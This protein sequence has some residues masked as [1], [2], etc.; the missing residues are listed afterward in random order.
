MLL[1]I[2]MIAIQ[3]YLFDMEHN[4]LQKYYDLQCELFI[5]G[6]IGYKLFV[7]LEKE[8]LKKYKLFTINLN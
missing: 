4:L 2:L 6:K 8:Y 1:E 5:E 3:M 7:E